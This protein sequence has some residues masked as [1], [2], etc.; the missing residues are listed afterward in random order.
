MTWCLFKHRIRL[1]DVV[2]FQAQ[3]VLMTWCLLSTGC[4]NDMVLIKRR[5]S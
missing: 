4:V 1:N 3:D 2:L 5:M